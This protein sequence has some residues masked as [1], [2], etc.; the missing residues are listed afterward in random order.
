MKDKYHNSK[1]LLG[2]LKAV[3]FIATFIGMMLVS[4]ALAQWSYNS[5]WLSG[6]HFTAPFF[7]FNPVS[8]Y[9]YNAIPLPIYDSFDPLGGLFSS[10]GALPS[11]LGNYGSNIIS[12]TII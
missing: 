6:S 9:S 7:S 11:G 4:E 8:N 12:E 10:S 2:C 5:D 3:M 1:R